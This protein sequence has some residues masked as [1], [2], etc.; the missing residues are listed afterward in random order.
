MQHFF[1]III[2][3]FYGLVAAAEAYGEDSQ[4]DIL[5]CIETTISVAEE[6]MT[7]KEVKEACDS[8]LRQNP[9]AIDNNPTNKTEPD[10][11][12][13]NLVPQT[14]MG[15]ADATLEKKS[16]KPKTESLGTEPTHLL[17]DRL[18][19]E[20]L[21]RSNRFIL[22]PHKRNYLLPIS[23]SRTPN[24][25]PYTQTDAVLSNLD[26]T[27]A[28][29]QLSVKILL[30]ENIFDK[31]G[32]LYLGYTN[33]ALWQ[34]YN[35]QLSAP[36]RES[37]H[38]PE[39]ILGFTNDW[40][41]FGFTNVLNDFTFNHQSNGQAGLLSRSWNRLMFNSVFEKGNFA[42][43]LNPWYRLPENPQRYPGDPSGDDNPDIVDYLGNFEFSSAYKYKS[44]IFSLQ[45]RNNLKKENRNTIELSWTFPVTKTMRGYLNYFDGYGHSLI[46]YNRRTQVFGVGIIFTDLF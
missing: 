45:I 20:A 43:A 40:K 37:D 31:N 13:D 4:N 11:K 1:L 14:L 12:S 18:A 8:V 26:N 6:S 35:H 46:D 9:N 30:R 24:I 28:E 41:I 27:E 34:V 33:H 23:H 42:F 15:T 16:T 19:I 2:S 36:F 7:I 10:K 29:F 38:Q 32:H 44:D 25:D 5:R 17:K 21:N 22:T 3:L 39:I